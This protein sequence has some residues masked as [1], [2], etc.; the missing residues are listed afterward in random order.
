MPW[1]A[2]NDST[3]VIEPTWDFK[4]RTPSLDNG[5]LFWAAFALSSIWEVEHPSI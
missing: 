4:N 3:G 2:L 1:V 5:Q